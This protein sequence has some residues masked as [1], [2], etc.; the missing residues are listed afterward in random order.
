MLLRPCFRSHCT[1]LRR[2]SF[3]S[4]AWN[5]AHASLDLS[6]AAFA[7]HRRQKEAVQGKQFVAGPVRRNSRRTQPAG[8]SGLGVTPVCTVCLIVTK[9]VV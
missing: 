9:Y 7:E 1:S 6:T 4:V 5:T 2:G 3:M 8:G